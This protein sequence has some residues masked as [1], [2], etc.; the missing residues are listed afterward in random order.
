MTLRVHFLYIS[1]QCT[2]KINYLN[3]TEELRNAHIFNHRIN[4]LR[5][6]KLS[7]NHIV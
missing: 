5:Y 2:K 1:T 4:L 3:I 6:I 7:I